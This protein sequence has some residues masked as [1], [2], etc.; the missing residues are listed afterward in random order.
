MKLSFSTWYVTMLV[1]K[2][3]HASIQYAFKEI[4]H[5]LIMLHE[6]IKLNKLKKKKISFAFFW[7][8]GITVRFFGFI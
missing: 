8:E 3:N 1:I 5:A 6:R 7:K 2:F 4:S